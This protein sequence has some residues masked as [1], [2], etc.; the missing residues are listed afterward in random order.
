MDS[1]LPGDLGEQE[2][3]VTAVGKGFLWGA[4][5]NFLKVDSGDG[6]TT[7]GNTKPTELHTLNG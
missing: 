7:V 6:C 3:T 1:W 4:D 2:W 5:E